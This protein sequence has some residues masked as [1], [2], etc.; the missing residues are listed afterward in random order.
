MILIVECL[1]NLIS[2]KYFENKNFVLVVQYKIRTMC[3]PLRSAK[4][5]ICFE[6]L[7][8]HNRIKNNAEWNN[9][10]CYIRMFPKKV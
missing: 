9:K 3:Y 7:L 2:L 8:V 10:I 4:L 5:Y 6:A 1:K